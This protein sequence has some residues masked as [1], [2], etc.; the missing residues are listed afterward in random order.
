MG[1]YRVKPGYCLHLPNRWFVHPGEEVELTGGLE[2]DVLTYQG[3]KVEP[4]LSGQATGDG[5]EAVQELAEPKGLDK[6][7]R[8]RAVRGAKN[9]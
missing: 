8:D 7:P 5:Q 1:R 2:Q 4:V 9:R 3:W 6:P